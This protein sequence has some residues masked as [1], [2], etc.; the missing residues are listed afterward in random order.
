VDDL[1]TQIGVGGAIA[2]LIIKEV[3]AFVAKLK[4]N[5][6]GGEVEQMRVTLDTLK[7]LTSTC[8]EQAVVLREVAAEQAR[9]SQELASIHECLNKDDGEG[10][11]LIYRRPSFER[12]IVV[13]GENVDKQTD[14]LQ[15]LALA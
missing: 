14:V 6:D 13:L 15:K 1:I 8:N 3:L 10:V 11:R 4:S 7:A 12:A 9:Q 2:Y 5:T